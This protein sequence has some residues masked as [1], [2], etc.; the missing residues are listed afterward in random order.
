MVLVTETIVFIADPIENVVDTIVSQPRQG[1][2]NLR[3]VGKPLGHHRQRPGPYWEC[4]GHR[5]EGLGHDR[6]GDRPN[7]SPDRSNHDRRGDTGL[8]DGYT[9]LRGGQDRVCQGHGFL[10]DSNMFLHRLVHK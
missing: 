7:T 4:P 8:H 9:F 5:R 10:R 1:L 6:V 3:L 2:L